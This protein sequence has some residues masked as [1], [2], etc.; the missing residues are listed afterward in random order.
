MGDRPGAF[1]RRAPKH[2]DVKEATVSGWPLRV[3]RDRYCACRPDKIRPIGYSPVASTEAPSCWRIS[4]SPLTI[5][6]H[7]SS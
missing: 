4:D 1:V 5:D 3:E 2:G 6:C 7:V